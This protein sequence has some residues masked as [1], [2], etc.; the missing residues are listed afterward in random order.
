MTVPDRPGSVTNA[1][2][3][4]S[5]GEVRVGGNAIGQLNTGTAP[6]TGDGPRGAADPPRAEVGVLTVLPQEM[7][8]VIQLLAGRP[9]YDLEQL[10]SGADAHTAVFD[11]PGGRAVRVVATRCLRPG[12][13]SALIA[14]RAMVERFHPSVVALVGIGG[15]ISETV[16]IGDVVVADQ[17]ICY[18]SRRI[19][20]DGS[21]H[22]SASQTVDSW[23]GHRLNS[24]FVTH[25]P[26]LRTADGELIPIHHGPIGSGNV[27]L[28]AARSSLREHLKSFN[29]KVLAVE[30]EA[31]GLAQAFHEADGKEVPS[32]WLTIRGI[33]DQANEDKGSEYHEL[34]SRHA[35]HV[36]VRLLPYLVRP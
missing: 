20:P 2:V 24:F 35:A 11:G 17:V 8:A 4:S 33:S 9:G 31:A 34:A 26:A 23:I 6:G 29:E 3:I 19:G 27:V 1:G 30:T 5:G 22:R 18:D 15:G 13:E 21:H 25:Q 28:T 36:L 12:T 16:K 7:K 14:Y 10:P 32:G